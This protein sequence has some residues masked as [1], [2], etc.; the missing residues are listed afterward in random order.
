M[1]LFGLGMTLVILFGDRVIGLRMVNGLVSMFVGVV[2]L[3]SGYLLGR[4]ERKD[5][6][7]KEDL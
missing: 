2:G 6:E 3:G 5:K 4:A 1:I 7:R